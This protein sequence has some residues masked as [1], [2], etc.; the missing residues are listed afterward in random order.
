MLA[1]R[2]LLMNGNFRVTRGCKHGS[3]W[4]DKQTQNGRLFMGNAYGHETDSFAPS[5]CVMVCTVRYLMP[6][7]PRKFGQA[8]PLDSH[9]TVS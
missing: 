4:E 5:H 1:N 3:G 8:L 6:F 7:C 9:C 2:V